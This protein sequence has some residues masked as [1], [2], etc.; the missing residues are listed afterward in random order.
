MQIV[1][2]GKGT[3]SAEGQVISQLLCLSQHTM[4]CSRAPGSVELC[5]VSPG[6]VLLHRKAHSV[7]Q[8][9]FL[10]G[11]HQRES[12]ILQYGTWPIWVFCVRLASKAL[13]I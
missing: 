6:P 11:A 2:R 3:H 1:Q 8:S 9:V 13:L 5:A 10:A 4:M 7:T 12:A